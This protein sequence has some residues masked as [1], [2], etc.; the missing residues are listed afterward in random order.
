MAGSIHGGHRG[1]VKGEFLLQGLSG[2]PEHRVMELLLYYAIP[3]G[4]V[5]GLAHTLIDRFGSLAGVL[6]APYEDLLRTP[7]VGEHTATLLKLIPAAGAAYV[8]SRGRVDT[9]VHCAADAYHLLSPYFFGA[10]NELVYLLCLD[11]KDQVLG[12]RKV[13]EG[14][15]RAADI[16]LRRIMEEAVS[17]RAARIY[18]AHNHVGSLALPSE[19]DWSTTLTL[20]GALDGV[21]IELVDHLVFQDD[22]MTSLRESQSGRIFLPL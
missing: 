7:G 1:R 12:V 17:L 14:S 11:G 13:S 21:G 8:R 10:R 15:I 2:W 22:E 16:N 3:Q 5:N 9:I 19:M 20:Y 6:D 18:L 4:D